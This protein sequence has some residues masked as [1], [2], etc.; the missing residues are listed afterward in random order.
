MSNSSTVNCVVLRCPRPENGAE[1]HAQNAKSGAVIQTRNPDA[2]SG[3]CL[4]VRPGILLAGCEPYNATQH[5]AD[6]C[7]NDETDVATRE[8]LVIFDNAPAAA[9]P[10]IRALNDP[11]FG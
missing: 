1:P 11:S 6:H 9:E 4:R 5:E 7:K 8:V 10:A 2:N 3:N